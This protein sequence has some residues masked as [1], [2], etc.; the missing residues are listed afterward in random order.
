MLCVLGVSEE[1]L[2]LA[3]L[4]L[5]PAIHPEHSGLSHSPLSYERAEHWAKTAL[6]HLGP[7]QM[8]KLWAWLWIKAVV[9]KKKM[10]LR[11][12]NMS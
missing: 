4:H 1:W 10:K 3:P 9:K 12:M 11:A 2:L 8:I 7:I 6:E 5:Y